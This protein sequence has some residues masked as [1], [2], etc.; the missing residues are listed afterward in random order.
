MLSSAFRHCFADA[1]ACATR[2]YATLR[3]YAIAGY[4][5]S[6]SPSMMPSRH[7]VIVVTPIFNAMLDYAI[8]GSVKIRHIIII[9]TAHLISHFRRQIIPLRWSPATVIFVTSYLAFIYL[10]SLIR[11]NI[12]K[13]SFVYLTDYCILF[14]S[15]PSVDAQ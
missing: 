11:H 4:T 10:H 13:H 1:F 5:I 14:T 6:I 12:S 2:H 15:L 8:S 7:D 9:A 3:H